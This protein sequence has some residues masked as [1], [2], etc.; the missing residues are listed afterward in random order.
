V[1]A[2]THDA[3]AM[4]SGIAVKCMGEAAQRAAREDRQLT[5]RQ[6]T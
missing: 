3:G 4:E 5:D 1:H 2:V 6:E